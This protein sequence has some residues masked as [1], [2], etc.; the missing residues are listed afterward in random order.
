MEFLLF[1]FWLLGLPVVA[2]MAAVVLLDWLWPAMPERRLRALAGLLATLAI[3]ARAVWVVLDARAHP[4]G[5]PDL[6]GY[7]VIGAIFFA[8]A[9]I[10]LSL[11]ASRLTIRYLRGEGA[12]E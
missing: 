1:F 9:G 4:S 11:L 8:L 10:P 7:I 2:A 5:S 3:L 6:E 12:R